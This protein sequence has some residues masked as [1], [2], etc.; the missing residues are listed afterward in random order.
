MIRINLQSAAAKKQKRRAA[1]SASSAGGPSNALPAMMLLLPVAAG[2]GGSYVVHSGLLASMEEQRAAIQVGEAE[3]A[4]LK[5]IIDELNQFKK[6]KALL[7]KKL[8]AIKTLEGARHGPVKIYAELG[9]L[10]PSQVWV[11]SLRESNKAAVMDGLGLDS[12]S[13]AVF[14]NALQRSRYFANV[15][16][17]TVESTKYLGLDV[18]KFSLTC[19]LVNPDAPPPPAAPAP[20]APAGRRR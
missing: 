11:T 13:I 4:R 8:A 9:A 7:E 10:M 5:P 15:E 6:D 18:K 14:V 20:A 2:L 12:Q 1:S 19:R 17:T 16:L 3:I